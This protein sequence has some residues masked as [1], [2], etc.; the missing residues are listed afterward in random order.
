MK[1]FFFFLFFS[2]FFSF[3]EEISKANV[4][5]LVQS[6]KTCQGLDVVSAEAQYLECLERANV[7]DFLDHVGAEGQV[8]DVDEG[9]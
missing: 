7:F 2:L 5:L 6:N 4:L 3:V 9:F 1:D 8:F